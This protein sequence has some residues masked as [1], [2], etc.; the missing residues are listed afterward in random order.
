V[1][2]I[3]GIAGQTNLL[4][5]NAAIEAAR[6][7]EQ[8]LGFAV[9]A[10]EV[11]QLAVQSQE[12]AKKISVIVQDVQV[13]TEKAVGAATDGEAAVEAGLEAIRLAGETL[14]QIVASVNQTA[15]EITDIVASSEAV[16]VSTNKLV[17]G[18]ETLSAAAQEAAASIEEVASSAHEQQADLQ[19]IDRNVQQLAGVA[20]SL[21]SLVG[22]FTV[23]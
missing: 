7:G 16:A 17:E 9:V 19:L 22:R 14:Q 5:L 10:K 18:M 1:A 11:R 13:E 21:N 12:A 6:A 3:S 23:S 20:Q 4:A 2:L 8:G 15:G